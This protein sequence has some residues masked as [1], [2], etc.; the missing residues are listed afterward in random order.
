MAT[1]PAKPDATSCAPAHMLQ[2]LPCSCR[3][4]H[5]LDR[6]AKVAWKILASLAACQIGT[7]QKKAANVAAE[8]PTPCHTGA[9]NGLAGGA[10]GA[11]RASQMSTLKAATM[12]LFSLASSRCTYL[13]S[14]TLNASFTRL[15]Y[16]SERFVAKTTNLR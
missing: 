15:K 5:V 16:L 6:S 11:G 12:T 9:S 10:P 8:R 2:E 3:S 1:T 7:C 4:P 14:T 13:L